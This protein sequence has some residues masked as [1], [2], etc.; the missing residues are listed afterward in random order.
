VAKSVAVQQ[1]DTTTYEKLAEALVIY[2]ECGDNKLGSLSE[3]MEYFKAVT[4]NA[5][6]C[7]LD[8]LAECVNN[9]AI[10]NAADIL[11]DLIK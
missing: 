7:L 8:V 4:D 11:K 9:K 2:K 6:C 3:R 5:I 10:P 1:A